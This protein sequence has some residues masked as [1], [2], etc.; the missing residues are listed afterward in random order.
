M[1]ASTISGV[2]ASIEWTYPRLIDVAREAPER[3]APEA[4][5]GGAP[6]RTMRGGNDAYNDRQVSKR[7]HFSPTELLAEQRRLSHG[8]KLGE[9]ARQALDLIYEDDSFSANA[10]VGRASAQL[11]AKASSSM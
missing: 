10:A 3:T 9:G 11:R 8:S 1:S 6:T 4:T 5:A 2:A 7:A